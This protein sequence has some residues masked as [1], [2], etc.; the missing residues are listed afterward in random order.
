MKLNTAYKE[1]DEIKHQID[2]LRRDKIRRTKVVKRLE[3]K[4]RNKQN[5]NDA[6]QQQLD[7][8]NEATNQYKYYYY[9]LKYRA[10]LESVE[11]HETIK[12]ELTEFDEFWME[13][14]REL[15]R[16]KERMQQE[17]QRLIATRTATAVAE[18][19]HEDPKITKLK[20]YNTI[21][22]WDCAKKGIDLKT[23]AEQ[24]NE[25]QHAFETMAES[26]GINDYKQI[27]ETIAEFEDANFASVQRISA[28]NDELTKLETEC[29]SLKEQLGVAKLSQGGTN[30]ENRIKILNNLNNEIQQSEQKTEEYHQ[31]LTKSQLLLQQLKRS[32]STIFKRVGCEDEILLKEF[33]I[34]GV[35]ETNVLNIMGVIEQR[36][37]EI[38]QMYYLQQKGILPELIEQCNSL[39]S[40]SPP[41]KLN[42][43]ENTTA[44]KGRQSLINS[45]Q[46]LHPPQV[47]SVTEIP[48]DIDDDNNNNNIC[49]GTIGS[50]RNNDNNKDEAVPLSLDEIKK[51]AIQ[52]VNKLYITNQNNTLVRAPPPAMSRIGSRVSIVSQSRSHVS[53]PSGLRPHLLRNVPSIVA[54]RRKMS[55][56]SNESG[57]NTPIS[58]D[59]SQQELN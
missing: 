53:T 13:G 26:S 52:T 14:I 32:I 31:S 37:M 9:Y 17:E 51:S 20:V 8:A 1:N 5:D 57:G 34:Q 55:M 47:P 43:D 22:F 48:D 25:Y 16:Q 3:K 2:D 54:A 29:S 35:T 39:S 38:A 42:I 50:L 24:V 18:E 10:K 19:W 36:V 49:T 46:P 6:L 4:Y 41:P 21:M 7:E 59:Q 28:L 56:N 33:S 11:I 27:I 44:F 40:N 30:H 58:N 15:D 45:V 12:A 23:Q